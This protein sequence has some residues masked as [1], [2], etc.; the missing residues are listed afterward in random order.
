ML[1]DIKNLIKK[2][3]V[4]EHVKLS[5]SDK[6]LIKGKLA[7]PETGEQ[8][9]H[10]CHILM[11]LN[12]GVS[13]ETV[14]TKA[15]TSIATIERTVSDFNQYGIKSALTEDP[16]PGQPERLTPS[17]EARL[18]S[19][20]KSGKYGS[21]QELADKLSSDGIAKDISDET[22]RIHLKKHGI[23]I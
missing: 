3:N 8:I 21:N 6:D 16:R 10:R 17:Q 13:Y 15:N 5:G 20:A 2:L 11:L 19:F 4:N 9:K 23:T 18:I 22:V 14:V 1:E 7:D 12:K